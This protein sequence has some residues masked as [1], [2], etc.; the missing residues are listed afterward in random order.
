MSGKSTPTKI[1][2]L[3][4]DPLKQKV[5]KITFTVYHKADL[6]NMVNQGTDD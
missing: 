5:L 1:N 4:S 3:H 6:E 2:T